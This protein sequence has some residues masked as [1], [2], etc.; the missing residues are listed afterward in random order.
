[1]RCR[2]SAFIA[3]AGGASGDLPLLLRAPSSQDGQHGRS[4][5]ARVSSS[6]TPLG[7][8]WLGSS[9]LWSTGGVSA[10][11]SAGGADILRADITR[12]YGWVLIAR[13]CLEAQ[14]GA[15]AFS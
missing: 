9:W 11:L 7:R 5:L 6:L 3:R 15:L 10:G 13:G 8:G 12:G 1:M 4:P 2:L 14:S